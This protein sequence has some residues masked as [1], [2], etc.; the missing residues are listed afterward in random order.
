M[1]GGGVALMVARV[2]FHWLTSLLKTVIFMLG[3]V[4]AT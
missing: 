1:K 4:S 2:L 3:G